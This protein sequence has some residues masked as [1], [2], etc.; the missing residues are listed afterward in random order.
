MPALISDKLSGHG[1]PA[2]RWDDGGQTAAMAMETL[3]RGLLFVFGVAVIGIS[4]GHIILG[5]GVIP[6]SVPVNATM[7][8]EDRFYATFFLAYG[9]AILWC[10]KDWRSRL[11]EIRVLMAIFFI[12]GLARLVS[13][14]AVGLPH[15]FFVAMTILELA[16]PP[17]VI[18]LGTRATRHGAAD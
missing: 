2:K 4:L 11:R 15:P 8:S 17:F 10:L 18:W 3:F 6:G 12:G 5:P 7:D 13:I 16:L 14:A 9:A 1:Q